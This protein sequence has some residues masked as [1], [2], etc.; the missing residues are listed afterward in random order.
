MLIR[1]GGGGRPRNTKYRFADEG[2]GGE[3][4]V[5]G[6]RAARNSTRSIRQGE[7]FFSALID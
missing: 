1:G 7:H 6:A 2:G 5:S 4:G 3:G